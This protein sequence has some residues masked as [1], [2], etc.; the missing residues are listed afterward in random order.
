MKHETQFVDMIEYRLVL[1][2]KVFKVKSLFFVNVWCNCLFFQLWAEWAVPGDSVQRN[3]S[4]IVVIETPFFKTTVNSTSDFTTETLPGIDGPFALILSH[5][6][7]TEFS[8]E[9]V[10]R[11]IAVS[12]YC[13][14]LIG[15][16]RFFVMVS[17]LCSVQRLRC[18]P[19]LSWVGVRKM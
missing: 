8:V 5:L 10:K 7:C 1:N 16:V 13:S 12:D 9:G 2:D 4:E 3:D 18:H 11:H 17:I 15:S 19:L 6:C 14:C